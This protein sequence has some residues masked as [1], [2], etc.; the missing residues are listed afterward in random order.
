MIYSL[1]LC[2]VIYVVTTLVIT[3]MVNYSEF[4]NV[5]DPLAYV[6]EKINMK[7]VGFIVSVSAVVAATSVLLVFQL[8][9][10]R[11]WMSMSRDGL[12]P[13][14]F[15]NIHPRYR[16]PSFATFVTGLLV[17]IP[18]L[19]IDDGLVTDLTSIGTLF[20]FV[21]VC[22]GVLLLPVRP[23]E[24]GKFHLPYINGKFIV[25]ALVILLIVGASKRLGAAFSN[26][27]NEG[28]QE[29][30]FIVFVALALYIAV[31]SF[32]RNYSLIPVLG[33]LCCA[34]LMIEIPAKSWLVFFLWMGLGLIIYFLYG[35]K[36]SK[37]SQ[38]AS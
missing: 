31:M 8:G 36:H 21:L 26:I 28:Y 38:G 24:V 19:V 30:L 5:T 1:I 32:L 6:F 25:P 18:V 29:V 27:G 7:A 35:A 37:L 15:S 17:G 14:R 4:E 10:P 16:T 23:K 2:T 3:G 11:I 12:L 20:A 33:M 34:Y 13:K 9:Q 22:G